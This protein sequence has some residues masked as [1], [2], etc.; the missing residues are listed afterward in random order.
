MSIFISFIGW[1][2]IPNRTNPPN[3]SEAFEETK[4]VANTK[5]TNTSNILGQRI[6]E[7]NMLC[8]DNGISILG[9]IRDGTTF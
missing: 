3:Y 2:L 5:I 7:L 6:T 9:V 1:R 4:Y 8:D